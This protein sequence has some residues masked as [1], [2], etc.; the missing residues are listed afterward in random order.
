[1]ENLTA[2][3]TYFNQ[4]ECSDK[5]IL[6]RSVLPFYNLIFCLKGKAIITVDDEKFK[7]E[8]GYATF[9]KKGQI[10]S[11]Y[12]LKESPLNQ[13][14]FNFDI[15]SD[16]IP[17][18]PD[19][20]Y[21]GDNLRLKSYF[22]EINFEWINKNENYLLKCN[23]ILNLIIFEILQLK[24]KNAYNYHVEKIKDYIFLH[25]KDNL[26]IEEISKKLNLH[27]TYCGAIFKKTTGCGILQYINNLRINQ[28]KL[29]LS[30]ND[31]SIAEIGEL[32]GIKDCYY[33]S[34]LFKRTVGISPLE[35]KKTLYSSENSL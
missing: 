15:L 17:D 29:L 33:F 28:S 23:S 25:F 35:Y 20:F 24:N 8:E 21:W 26:T 5:W 11:A 19:F 16:E 18:L 31:L 32:V 2:K 9:I 6:E 3:I 1:M 22:K 12:T 7:L 27:P 10:R 13:V 14:A 30:E 4:R 34:K